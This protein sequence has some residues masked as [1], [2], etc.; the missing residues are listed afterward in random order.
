MSR[1]P[2]YQH[3]AS[4]NLAETIGL[5]LPARGAIWAL[6]DL[7]WMRSEDYCSVLDDDV[8]IARDLGCSLEAWKA[9]RAEI[10]HPARPIFEEI[11]GRLVCPRLREQAAK[12]EQYRRMQAE[13]SKKGGEATRARWQ[14]NGGPAGL[15]RAGQRRAFPIPNSELR[16]SS[17][18][19][20]SELQ[21]HEEEEE[22]SAHSK[23]NGADAPS[24]S[25]KRT[26]QILKT[27]DQEFLSK[28]RAD[29]TYAGIDVDTEVGKCRNWCEVNGESFSRQRFVNWLN[30]AKPNGVNAKGASHVGLNA[31]DYRTGW[32]QNAV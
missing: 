9:L 28:L 20:D 15:P 3:Y 22:K 8:M 23:T 14:A 32:G 30:K 13:K 24:A 19:S 10:Q 5:S 16:T 21:L 6:R 11:N 26:R 31:K 12:Q 18:N 2:A 7:A 25:L 29:R 27:V 1:S 4:D 17:P